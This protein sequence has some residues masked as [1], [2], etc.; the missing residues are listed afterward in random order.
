MRSKYFNVKTVLLSCALLSVS[1]SAHS[2]DSTELKRHIAVL[3]ALGVQPT[4][5]SIETYFDSLIGNNNRISERETDSLIAQLGSDSYQAREQATLR[6]A[7]L[8]DP[9]IDKL[10]QTVQAHDLELATRARHVLRMLEQL[11]DPRVAMF[12]VIQ[13]RNI[14][15]DLS[16]MLEVVA[17]CENDEALEAAMDAFA[18]IVG[19]E[20]AQLVQRS[21][22]DVRVRVKAAAVLALPKT[23]KDND[24][25]VRQ[26]HVWLDDADATIRMAAARAL[27]Q[28]GESLDAD[29]YAKLLIPATM[30][31][32]LRAEEKRFRQ[33]NKDRL[34][35]REAIK[36][37]Q[38]LLIRYVETLSKVKDVQR[39]KKSA[40]RDKHWFNQGL[41]TS[42]HPELLMYRIRWFSGGWSG[43]FVPGFN[44]RETGK[45]RNVRHWGCFSDHEHEIIVT[46]N[47]ELYREIDDL[48]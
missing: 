17:R 18:A 25:L 47:K 11:D 39:A 36:Q 9:P 27:I 31:V 23:L 12:H 38:G 15:V 14:Q 29:K 20:D 6:L 46:T 10:K 19:D 26:L 33:K 22:A 43:W 32:L 13:L 8:D 4:A 45:G 5:A 30:A 24:K 16:K 40:S 28:I 2:E 44:D 41:D 37:Y 3:R 34:K 48:R 7:T 35:D 21:L 42:K 1:T